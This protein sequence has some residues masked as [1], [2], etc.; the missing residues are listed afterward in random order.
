MHT[1]NRSSLFSCLLGR[2]VALIIVLVF[3]EDLGSVERHVSEASIYILHSFGTDKRTGS[4]EVFFL[5]N[6]INH[7]VIKKFFFSDEI[8]NTTAGFKRLFGNARGDFVSDKRIEGGNNT[9]RIVDKSSAVFSVCSDSSNAAL[10]E[11]I[12]SIGHHA[13]TTENVVYNERFR[14]IELKL[15][16]FCSHG[17]CQVVSDHLKAGL[18]DGFRNHRIDL[19]WHDGRTGLYARKVDLVQPTSRSA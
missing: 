13:K 9:N 16:C 18:V 5:H 8:Q 12:A 19:A 7:C 2:L 14:E 17:D 11:H 6:V 3:G 10:R 15:S 4:C 1:C